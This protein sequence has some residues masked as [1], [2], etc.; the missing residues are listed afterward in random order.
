MS[1][2]C[3]LTLLRTK[4]T[5]NSN[6]SS[7]VPSTDFFLLLILWKHEHIIFE[8]CWN[9]CW[10][11]K[12]NLRPLLVQC[13]CTTSTTHCEAMMTCSKLLIFNLNSLAVILCLLLLCTATFSPF[14]YSFFN[15]VGNEPCRNNEGE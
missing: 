11:L 9:F 14:F 15:D 4:I 2:I 1:K 3:L 12:S 7:E 10:K 5:Q 8:F 13:V 6:V